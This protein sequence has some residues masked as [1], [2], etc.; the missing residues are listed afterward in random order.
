LVALAAALALLA[1]VPARAADAPPDPKKA[2]A[3]QRFD[4]GLQLFDDGDTAGA[5]AEFKR[6][7]ELVPNPVV[8]FN[9]GL[10]YAAMGRPVSAVDAL[11]KVMQTPDKLS[12][13]QRERATRTLND[14]KQRIGRLM[15]TT[16][17]EGARI[18]IDN[19]ESARTPLTAPIRVSEGAHIIGAVAEGYAPDRKEVVVAGNAEAT[20]TFELVSTQGKQLANLTVRSRIAG[21]DV[22]IDNKPAGKTP[23]ATSVT[24]L[25]GHHVVELKRPGYRPSRQEVDVGAGATGELSFELAV[26]SAQLSAEGAMLAI[27]ASEPHP[28]LFVDD[29]HKGPYTEPV[30]LPRGPHRLRIEHAG[31][32]PVERNVNLDQGQTSLVHV[33]L[34]PTPEKR[35]AYASSASFHRTWGIIGLAGGAAIAGGGVAWLLVSAGNSTVSQAQAEFDQATAIQGKASNIGLPLGDPNAP[36]HPCA[37]HGAATGDPDQTAD[38]PDVCTAYV[39]GYA[40]TLNN[41]KK[42]DSRNK[43]IGFVGI[44]VGAAIAVT[45]LV[46]LL[47][48]D[49]P[50]RYDKPASNKLGKRRSPEGPKFAFGPGPGQIGGSFGVVF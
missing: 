37:T 49:D 17:P 11:E 46:L 44:G 2:E 29:E 45:G 27:D 1:T 19:V 4:R 25:A 10:V 22:V 6:T 40:T 18:D 21:A 24:L 34:E 47:T 7:Y 5:L 23:L 26:D 43:V 38:D 30:R 28:V 3:A 15:V 42:T 31:F 48:G 33:D 35:A 20:V 39:Q 36:Q 8:L 14:Q 41:A 9:I 16:V 32:L 12:T 13:D 50:G